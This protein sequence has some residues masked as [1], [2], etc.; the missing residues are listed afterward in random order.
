TVS[1]SDAIRRCFCK[2][3]RSRR[4]RRI[5]SARSRGTTRAQDRTDRTM[6]PGPK[7]FSRPREFL[8]AERKGS[9]SL[10]RLSKRAWANSCSSAS[11][12]QRVAFLVGGDPMAA[13]TH[14]DLRLRAASAGIPTRIV[15]GASI[16]TAAAGVL[17]LQIY[18]FGRTT[19][20]P[21]PSEGFGPTSP[22]EVILQNRSAGLHSLVLLDLREDGTFLLAG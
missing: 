21:F 15:H 5:S 12:G 18:K 16:L 13:T 3:S 8:Q 20:I 6:D 2:R 9:K 22:L 14:V 19:T 7:G 1:P 4:R 10:V 11:A 17:G